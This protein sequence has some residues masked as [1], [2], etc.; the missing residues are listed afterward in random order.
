MLP[1]L[2]LAGMISLD[3]NMTGFPKRQLVASKLPI[4]TNYNM[5]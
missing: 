1:Q 3:S 2:L 4:T 5:I